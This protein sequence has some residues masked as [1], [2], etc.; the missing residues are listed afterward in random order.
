MKSLL[1]LII[2]L[3]TFVSRPALAQNFNLKQK[4]YELDYKRH[5]H[6]QTLR[7]KGNIIIGKGET[8]R[9]LYQAIDRIPR[10]LDTLIVMDLFGGDIAVVNKAFKR[11]KS[12]C[13][14]RGYRVCKIT[15]QIEM[16]RHCASA[17]V[18]LFM[19]GH[20]RKVSHFAK[21]GFHQAAIAGGWIK[22]PFMSER[23]LRLKGV[24]EKW[25]KKNKHL[26]ST[27][28]VTWLKPIDLN[29][30]GIIHQIYTTSDDSI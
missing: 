26:F 14:D 5:G 27:L 13:E 10:G 12:I 18:P 25:I 24:N 28:K 17:C 3:F 1:L 9:S 21:F 2:T 11:L 23:E 30:S 8:A 4:R 6:S 16:F 20:Y 7:I 29:G 19:V 22:I 15:T